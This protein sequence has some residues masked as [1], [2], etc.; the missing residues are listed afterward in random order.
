VQLCPARTPKSRCRGNWSVPK[1]EGSTATIGVPRSVIERIHRLKKLEVEINWGGKGSKKKFKVVRSA[2][3]HDLVFQSVVKGTSMN[4]QNIVR[5]HLRP[6]AL[7]LKLNPKKVTW[8][9]LRTSYG[10]WESV[11][12]RDTDV[13]TTTLPEDGQRDQGG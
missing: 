3:P 4:D 11:I 5:R 1:T 6:A 12:L 2:E 7:K 10:T 9:A 8:R 13:S